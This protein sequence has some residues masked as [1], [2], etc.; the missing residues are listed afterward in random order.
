MTDNATRGSNSTSNRVGRR[1][2]ND[3]INA[4]IRMWPPFLWA[5][6]PQTDTETTTTSV[7]GDH[8][9]ITIMTEEMNAKNPSLERDIVRKVASYGEQLGRI[10]DAL[11]V[12]IS[13]VILK[14][15]P[16][17]LQPDERQSLQ[18]FSELFRKIAK[19]KGEHVAPTEADLDFLLH[20]IQSLEVKDPPTYE[21]MMMKLRE[22]AKG[23][24]PE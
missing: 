4:W 15:D 11:S 5:F 6:A 16:S 1:P 12:L 19:Q 20:E 18:D 10:N 24:Q 14:R 3:P 13:L 2:P 8:N 22:F 17:N 21:R 7:A 23:D 9:F